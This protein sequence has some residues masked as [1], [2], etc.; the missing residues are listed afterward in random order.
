MSARVLASKAG[1]SGDYA[2]AADLEK[3]SILEAF[4]TTTALLQQDPTLR[5]ALTLC[6]LAKRWPREMH[7]A[8][9]FMSKVCG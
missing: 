8:T 6:Q 3:R 2:P 7:A 9:A 5:A 1:L 4:E